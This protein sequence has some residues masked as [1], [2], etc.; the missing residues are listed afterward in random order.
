MG[1]GSGRNAFFA[2]EVGSSRNARDEGADEANAYA[3]SGLGLRD[4]AGD[5]GD[6][7]GE[8][9]TICSGMLRSKSRSEER[10]V[11]PPRK[12]TVA[13]VDVVVMEL[14]VLESCL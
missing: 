11:F 4:D 9:S 2:A 13:V 3:G 5:S 7:G 6:G 14:I 8:A 12:T 10:G 1:G